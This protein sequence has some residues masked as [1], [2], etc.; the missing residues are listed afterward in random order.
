LK[1]GSR[2]A[3]RESQETTRSVTS[4]ATIVDEIGLE[5]EAS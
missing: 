2:S 4:A 5:K 1:L 3:M